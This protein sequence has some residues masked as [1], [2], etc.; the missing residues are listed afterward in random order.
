MKISASIYSD[1]QRDLKSTI[2]DL[3]LHQV[4][5]VH[6]DC[7][8]EI[9][10]FDDIRFIQKETNLPIDLHIISSNPERFNK[11]LLKT[12]PDYVTFQYEALTKK[13]E[14]PDDLTSKVGLAITTDTPIS[15]FEEYAHFDFILIMATIPGQSGGKFDSANF[16]K[17][18]EFRKKYPQKSIHVDG[19]VNGEVSFILRSMGVSTAVSGSYLFSG[20][21]VGNALMNLTKRAIH[22][23]YR[24]CDFM[25]PLAD[26]HL[27]RTDNLSVKSILTAV[28]N[29]N[30]GFALVLGENNELV[31][32]VSSADIRKAWLNNLD[33]IGQISPEKLI[34]RNPITI[35]EYANVVEL[36]AMIKQ[37]A[38]PIAYL[39]V[40]NKDGQALGI[41]TFANLIK[42]EL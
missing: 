35:H 8:D 4:D 42:G 11:E 23:D 21:S 16:M 37:T 5:L 18:N 13:L 15:V 33:N 28:E 12:Q 20:P 22:S 34:N 40:V 2:T 10:V 17:I 24:V 3:N 19:G 29:S 39:P 6:V 32:L 27:I 1:K 26:L 7:N 30:V 41:I 36:L 14:L 31:G 9:A 25:V 38:F